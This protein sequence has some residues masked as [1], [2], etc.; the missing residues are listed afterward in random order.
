MLTFHIAGELHEGDT[1]I[2]MLSAEESARYPAM[3]VL[4]F[5]LV[6][7]ILSEGLGSRLPEASI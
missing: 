4:G 2:R 3:S 1:F 7:H 5:E 6:Q